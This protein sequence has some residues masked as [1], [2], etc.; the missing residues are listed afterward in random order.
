[1]TTPR[2]PVAHDGE[3]AAGVRAAYDAIARDYHQQLGE[4]L[5]G[6]PLDRGVLQ[7]FTELAAEGPVADVGCGPGHVTRFLAAR[8]PGVIGID[9]SP[10]MIAVAREHAPGLPFAVGSMVQLPAADGA[11]SGIIALYSIIHLTSRERTRAGREF[12]R[13]LRDGGWLLVAFHIDSPDFATGEVNHLT[14][15]FG[16][17]V[18]LDGY[19][20]EPATVQR[21][22]EAAGFT[23]AA[24]LIR[25]PR[26]G[27]EYPS[28]R[29]YLLAQRQ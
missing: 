18:S 10:G 15:W 11:W 22:L 13:A 3:V 23:I 20:L 28:R 9:I 27:I 17:A 19:F 1:M 12:A 16:Q 25:A 4:E 2:D 26:P 7:A 29:C 8:R 21:D 5:A 6:K 14:T 24:T